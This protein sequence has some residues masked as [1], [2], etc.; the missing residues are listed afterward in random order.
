MN[1]MTSIRT[2]AVQRTVLLAALAALAGG[3]AS[4]RFYANYYVDPKPP[5]VAYSDLKKPSS[6]N[7]VYLVFDMY[8]A[9]G[10]FPEATRKIGPKVA[11][12]LQNSHLF[13][14]VSSVGSENIPRLQL[15]MRETAVLTGHDAKALPDGLTSGLSGSRG[16]I[17]YQFTAQYQ[18]PGKEAVKKVYPHAVHIV[19]GTDP[20]L[21]DSMPLTAAHAV[22]EMVERVTLNL[23]RDLQR[24]GK[25]E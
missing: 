11:R 5:Q 14:N 7:P 15:S 18:A 4:E 13:S 24:E 9:E 23:L 20:K 1:A 10:S 16:V 21:G 22:D 17:V 19:E 2:V 3:C 8:S 6:P 12:V 25:L